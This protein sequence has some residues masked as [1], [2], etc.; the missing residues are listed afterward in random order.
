MNSHI[1]RS[2]SLVASR[3]RWRAGVASKRGSHPRP[4]ERLV[5]SC[6][7]CKSTRS[8]VNVIVCRGKAD[9]KWA[10]ALPEQLPSATGH[11]VPGRISISLGPNCRERPER[12]ADPLNRSWCGIADVAVCISGQSVGCTHGKSFLLRSMAKMVPEPQST[13]LGMYSVRIA[14]ERFLF[15]WTEHS[16][17]AVHISGVGFG[18]C[19]APSAKYRTPL[20]AKRSGHP[21]PSLVS[22]TRNWVGS[23]CRPWLPGVS[24]SRS[25]S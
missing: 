20:Q 18:P 14:G 3:G 22:I 7:V 12:E 5:L 24:Y 9:N 21:Q 23:I 6:R 25:R 8:N 15:T 16:L 13:D 4:G 1:A 2:I 10:A 11:V 19:W 17:D